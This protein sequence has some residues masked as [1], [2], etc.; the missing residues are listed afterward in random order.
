M[1]LTIGVDIG[2]TKIAIGVIAQ[3]GEILQRDHISS[4]AN[5]RTKI[6]ADV[7]AGINRL[8]AENDVAAIGI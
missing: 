2:G 4:P 8:R 3:S 7:I 1:S 5:D 6:H